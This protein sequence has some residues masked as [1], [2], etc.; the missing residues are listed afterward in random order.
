ML[1]AVNALP[2]LSSA[3][4]QANRTFPQ[5]EYS[6]RLAKEVEGYKDPVYLELKFQDNS[7]RRIGVVH[8]VHL[9]GSDWDNQSYEAI[10]KTTDQVAQAII[11]RVKLFFEAETQKLHIDETGTI[12]DF[13]KTNVQL[14]EDNTFLVNGHVVTYQDKPV[15]LSRIQSE[16]IVQFIQQEDGVTYLSDSVDQREG[17]GIFIDANGKIYRG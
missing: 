7:I 2:N 5:D 15:A 4:E 13:N 9:T 12:F 6:V 1:S 14:R 8:L 10:A 16:G 3:I 11:A 17:K